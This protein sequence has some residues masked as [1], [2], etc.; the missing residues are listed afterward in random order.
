MWADRQEREARDTDPIIK[1]GIPLSEFPF[2]L[3]VRDMVFW[4]LMET[5]RNLTVHL[6]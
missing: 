6:V 4:I 2:Q 3:S 1:S 5:P